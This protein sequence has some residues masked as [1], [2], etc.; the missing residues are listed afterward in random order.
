MVGLVIN[1]N[2]SPFRFYQF[3]RERFSSKKDIK[4]YFSLKISGASF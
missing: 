1:L 2:E 3:I 4:N